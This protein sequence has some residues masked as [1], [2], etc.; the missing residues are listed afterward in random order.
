M[1]EA[2]A[3]RMI[4]HEYSLSFYGTVLILMMFFSGIFYFL[5]L[6]GFF[7]KKE[8]VRRGR[9]GGRLPFVT[10]QIPTRNDAVA[11]RCAKK[12][13][14][15]DYPKDRFEIIIGDDSDDRD[16]SRRIDEFAK[17]HPQVKVTR[18][19]SNRGFKAGNLNYMLKRSKGEIIVVFD[20]DFIPSRDFLKKVVPPFMK[21]RNVGC[22]QTKWQYFNLGQNRVTKLAS[23]ILMV[24]HNILA[25]LNSRN[26][27][28]LLFGSAQAVRK[29]LLVK[30]GG[31]QEGSLTEDVEFS[32]RVLKEGYRTVYLSNYETKGEVPFTLKSFFRQQRKWAYGN[33]KAFLEHCKWILFGKNL[34]PVQRSL[35]VFTL[36]GY[37]SG[38]ILVLFTLS[39]IISFAT[40]T[41]SPINIHKFLSVTGWML[42]VNSGFLAAALVAL[43]KEKRIRMALSVIGS[44]LTVGFV[45]SIGVA[46]GFVKALLRKRMDWYVVPKT[47]EKANV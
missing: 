5:A 17:R 32:L 22:V 38:P 31:W 37:V 23:A 16:V 15:F 3:L 9:I 14:Q 20:S 36:V 4:I 29:D 12:C 2:E 10:V 13:L 28:S 6:Y 42:L 25:V 46:Q 26:N 7:I 35:L 34:S 1:I 8:G 43:G 27:V 41:P 24:Y 39:G 18:R 11:L 19:G 47:G 33:T 44:S 21:D 30:M 45:V 40:G